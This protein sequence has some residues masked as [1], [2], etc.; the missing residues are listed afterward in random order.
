MLESE[1][2]DIYA[3]N[4][5]KPFYD[6][7]Y[8]KPKLQNA[9]MMAASW[10]RIEIVEIMIKHEDFS[11]EFCDQIDGHDNST[12]MMLAA[13]SNN[14][15][16]LGIIVGNDKCSKE[17]TNYYGFNVDDIAYLNSKQDTN[18]TSFLNNIRAEN[19]EDVYEPT[20]YAWVARF[21]RYYFYIWL[22][23]FNGLLPFTIVGYLFW[24]QYQNGKIEAARKKEEGDEKETTN[25]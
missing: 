3:V 11:P 10:N 15:E 17:M 7:A 23:S 1:K 13:S 14:I 22:F 19:G 24:A 25:L 8:C 9:F 5:C 18:V 6:G 4:W 2:I 16:I 20:T 21:S 12:A